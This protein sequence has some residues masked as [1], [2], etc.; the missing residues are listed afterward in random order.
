MET[1]ISAYSVKINTS[2]SILFSSSLYYSVLFGLPPRSILIRSTQSC[3]IPFYHTVFSSVLFQF[4]FVPFFSIQFDFSSIL[5]HSILFSCIFV[6]VY[7]FYFVPFYS[8]QLCS[9]LVLILFYSIQFCSISVLL[10][11]ILFYSIF[12]LFDI[13]MFYVAL[14]TSIHAN[15]HF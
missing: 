2:H 15:K 8:I 14:F 3:S 10:C 11:S 13:F 1:W 6:P 7:F 5:F 4:Y 9:I 12:V